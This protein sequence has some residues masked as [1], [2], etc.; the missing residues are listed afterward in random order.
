MLVEQQTSQQ[1]S[2]RLTFGFFIKY[3]LVR[4][5]ILKRGVSGEVC[6]LT[7]IPRNLRDLTD[8]YTMSKAAER[9][10]SIFQARFP[11]PMRL[12]TFFCR[13]E[14]RCQPHVGFLQAARL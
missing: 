9:A 13:S 10:N 8:P 4:A 12:C 2:S 14:Y 5:G 6:L 11:R 3:Q 1:I 7:R